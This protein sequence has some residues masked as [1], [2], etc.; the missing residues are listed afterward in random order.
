MYSGNETELL[1]CSTPTIVYPADFI[2]IR[3]SSNHLGFT[4]LISLGYCH[5]K[6]K[7]EVT[8]FELI[9]QFFFIGANGLLVPHTCS[10]CTHLSAFTQTLLNSLWFF[11]FRS[12]TTNVETPNISHVRQ[13]P[14]MLVSVCTA[15]HTNK[16]K[17]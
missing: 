6:H 7:I 13:S 16:T 4:Y 17:S 12:E 5:N 11:T 10:N 15:T 9:N 14:V 1:I 3:Y 8:V 2:F